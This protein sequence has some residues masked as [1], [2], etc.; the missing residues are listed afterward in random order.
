VL[1]LNPF[2]QPNVAESKANTTRVL[3]EG[4]T[5]VTVDA[6]VAVRTWLSRVAPGD[7][8]AVMAYVPPSPDAD[9]RLATLRRLLATRTGVAVTVG[10]GPR[11][12]H[13]TGQLHKGGPPHGHFLQLVPPA[14]RDAAIPGAPYGF[15]ELLHA[16]ADGD[17]E[18][19]TA[20]GRPVLRIADW[21]AL[22]REIGA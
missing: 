1:G 14:D 21:D 4:T 13:S 16:Q 8:V 6:P 19:L 10:Y 15:A 2:D 12:L 3:A 5:A 7:Y 11:F 18:A 9:A 20:R 22:E 17:W